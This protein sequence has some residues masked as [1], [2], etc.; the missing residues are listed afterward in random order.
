MPHKCKDAERAWRRGYAKRRRVEK[1]DLLRSQERARARKVQDFIRAFKVEH[2]CADCGYC[3]HHAALDFDHIDEKQIN[4]CNAKSV[5]QATAEIA[6]CEVV[7]ANC[8]RVRTFERLQKRPCKPDI[9]AATY[10]PA[11]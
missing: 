1:G 2:G 8:H 11:E 5:Q 7:C 6:R 9:F 3:A 4:V 10:E